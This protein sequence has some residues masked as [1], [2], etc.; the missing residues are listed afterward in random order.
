MIF[1]L[2]KK[3]IVLSCAYGLEV[4][5]LLMKPL[6]HKKT[7]ILI[8]EKF[9]QCPKWLFFNRIKKIKYYSLHETMLSKAHTEIFLWLVYKT[10]HFLVSA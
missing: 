2:K 6:T 4:M 5:K 7:D 10:E 8:W 3:L 9:Y 1:E